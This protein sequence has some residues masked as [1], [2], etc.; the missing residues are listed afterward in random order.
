MCKLYLKC[1]LC[2]PVSFSWVSCLPSIVNSAELYSECCKIFNI[3]VQRVILLLYLHTIKIKVEKWSL[4]GQTYLWNNVEGI[5]V[6]NNY[7]CYTC[8]MQ[9]SS[10]YCFTFYLYNR[11]GSRTHHCLTFTQSS[12]SSCGIIRG[13]VNDNFLLVCTGHF[14]TTE[15]KQVEAVRSNCGNAT[16]LK[17]WADESAV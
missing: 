7:Y 2:A 4:M 6:S 3:I 5:I 14:Y 11:D 15:R 12:L 16:S 17:S 8:A 13:I 10:N 9:S 1:F